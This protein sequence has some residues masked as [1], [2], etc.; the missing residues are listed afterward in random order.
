[1]VGR[2]TMCR[3]ASSRQPS[4]LELVGGLSQFLQSPSA[5][6]NVDGSVK[7]ACSL[8]D[9]S[10]PALWHNDVKEKYGTVILVKFPRV[11]EQLNRTPSLMF[12][13]FICGSGQKTL[14]GTGEAAIQLA[15]RSISF[16][17]GEAIWGASRLEA[18]HVALG[19]AIIALYRRWDLDT[20]LL[21]S[22]GKK[23]QQPALASARGSVI[24]AV[25]GAITE[26]CGID[27]MAAVA[28]DTLFSLAREGV[29]RQV[30]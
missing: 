26:A 20:L 8:V 27:A 17:R 24:N 29:T 7:A 12:T 9:T 2:A 5:S 18:E 28:N 30:R 14:A 6:L 21:R 4:R 3:F 25:F 23:T 19:M 15:W 13:P 11:G 1:M 10:G 16:Q 22:N